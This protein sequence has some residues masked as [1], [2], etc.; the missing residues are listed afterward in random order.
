M[1]LYGFPLSPLAV[2]NVYAG[3]Q[4]LLLCIWLHRYYDHDC[5][6][7]DS[8]GLRLMHTLSKVTSAHLSLLAQS[9]MPDCDG[10]SPNCFTPHLGISRAYVI[11]ALGPEGD[12]YNTQDPK[13]ALEAMSP[14]ALFVC[15][16]TCI[17]RR[18]RLP[19]HSQSGRRCCITSLSTPRCAGGTHG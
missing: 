19:T 11:Q 17:G 16:E 5:K 6:V 15:S 10:P 14:Q 4:Q 18:V 3:F 13:V 12:P 2:L 7:R 9:R 8:M 1:C